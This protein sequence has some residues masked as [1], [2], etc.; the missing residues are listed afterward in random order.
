MSRL[1]TISILV[2]LLAVPAA[3]ASVGGGGGGVGGQQDAQVTRS[4]N[5]VIT[6]LGPDRTLTMVDPKSEQ[7]QIIT[8]QDTVKLR[9]KSKKQFGRKQLTWDDL[10]EGQNVRVTFRADSG[11]VLQITVLPT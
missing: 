5:L 8:L 7:E 2:A 4:L 10:E 3:F 6:E 11:R 9:A 1:L